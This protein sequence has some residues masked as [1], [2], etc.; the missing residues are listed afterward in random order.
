[1]VSLGKPREKKDEFIAKRVEGVLM[2]QNR[3]F[4]DALNFRVTVSRFLWFRFLRIDF[5][6]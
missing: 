1:M 6:A 2:H 5:S 3:A 4:G